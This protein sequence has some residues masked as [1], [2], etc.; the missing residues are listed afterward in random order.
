[1]I[2]MLVATGGGAVATA[3]PSTAP[4][5]SAPAALQQQAPVAADPCATTTAPT[6][7]TTTAPTT[8]PAAPTSCAEVPTLAPSTSQT[9]TTGTEAPSVAD[10][11]APAPS[12]TPPAATSLTPSAEATAPT[13]TGERI[14][15]TGLPTENPNSTLIPGK[16]RSDREE[17]PEPF[18]KEEA[19]QAEIGEARLLA[20][21]RTSRAAATCQK[22]WPSNFDVCGA[23][24]DKYNSLGGTFSFLLLPTSGNIVNPGNTGERVTFMNGPIYWSAAGG[25]HP[26]VNSFLNRWGILGYEGSYLKYPTTDEIVLPDGGRRQE[27]QDGAIYVAF[28][29]A[30][31]SAIQNGPLRDKYNSVG[32]LTPGSS[33]LGYLTGD[34]IRSLPDGQGQMAR[35]QNGVIYWSPAT[36]AWPITEPVLTPWS[37]SGYESGS[38]KYPTGQP[39][40]TDGDVTIRQD[41]QGGPLIAPGPKVEQLAVLNPGASAPDVLQEAQRLSAELGRTL[42]DIVE[43]GLTEAAEG[44]GNA[45]PGVDTLLPTPR[46]PGD[47]FFSAS[48]TARVNHGHNGL[49]ITLTH[50]IEANQATDGV[51]IID[52]TIG[53]NGGRMMK[54]PEMFWVNTSSAMR[55]QAVDFALTKVGAG[56]N[57]QFWSNKVVDAVAYNCS[58]LVWAAYYGPSQGAV[59]LD[60]GGGLGVWPVDLKYSNLAVPY[61]A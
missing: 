24:R 42:Q 9:P 47:F 21:Q 15:Y 54:S 40:S 59:D 25:A 38:Y 34:H 58:Q 8:T 32:G 53:S 61:P 39:Y 12:S 11:P 2:A 52:N 7:T 18:T 28:Q 27:F 41:F 17:W 55:Q 4:T 30:I 22:Y 33:P 31:G 57:P 5:S 56:Y 35:F 48:A 10:A 3:Q 36:G 19:D 44:V 6:T 46:G 13:P 43:A 23:I 45:N 20:K 50:S 60:A 37:Q 14:P 1:M 26:V 16:M 51:Y 29:N 49:F